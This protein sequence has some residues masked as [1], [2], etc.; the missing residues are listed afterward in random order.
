MTPG[1]KQVLKDELLA[2]LTHDLETLAHAHE[3]ATAG[4]THE[5]A[6]PENDKDTR[7]LEQ[8]YLARGQARRVAELSAALLELEAMAI[9]RF[10]ADQPIA[11][12]ALV[13]VEENDKT[14]LLFIAGHGGG[15]L[16]AGG[17]VQVVSIKSPL[18]RALLG[19]CVGEDCDVA[20][21]GR[22]RELSIDKVE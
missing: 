20:L 21:P 17:T 5:E 14:S 16:L 9:Q 7:A 6:K 13:S 10:S 19:K 12:G 3:Q 1:F 4:A 2:L 11:V 18:G 22:V 15:S 8:S